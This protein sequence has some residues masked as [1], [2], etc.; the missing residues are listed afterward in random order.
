MDDTGDRPVDPARARISDRLAAVAAGFVLL[1]FVVASLLLARVNNSPGSSDSCGN[2]I[3][4]RSLTEG[5]GYVTGGLGELW[6]RQPLDAPDTVRPPGLPYLLAAVFAATGAALAVPVLVNAATVVLGALALR[7]AIRRRGGRRSADLAA[8]LML[9]SINYEMVSIWNNNLLAAFT[10]ALLFLASRAD[11]GASRGRAWLPVSLAVCSAA[12]L[13]MKQSFLLTAIP[14]SILVL[15]TDSTRTKTRRGLEVFAYLGLFLALTAVYWGPNVLLHGQPFYSPSFPSA[16]LAARYGFLPNGA[17]RTVRFDRPATYGEVLRALGPARMLLIDLKMLAKTIFYSICMN[18][19]VALAAAGSILFWRPSRRRD[20]AG[21]AALCA[22]TVFE[23][24]IYHHHE[25]R[26]LWP[27][28]PCFLLLA[29]FTVRDFDQWGTT[30][31]SPVLKARFRTAFALLGTCALLIGTFGALENWRK[32][33][34]QARQPTPGWAGAVRR[35][36]PASVVLTAD[37]G[38]V[39]WWTERRAVVSPLGDR[40]DLDAVLT[41]YKPDHYL[42]LGAEELPGRGVAFSSDDL[43]PLQQGEGWILYRIDLKKS[44]QSVKRDEPG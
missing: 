3:L 21:V 5:R 18:P 37:V 27:M 22:G 14:F 43:V 7:G 44:G 2:L 33:Y 42:A 25:F 32:A 9:L 30:Q 13:L 11:E 39:V 6:I 34:E 20:Y 40:A 8:I 36:P 17:W 26:Y 28:Y 10:A 23:V 15:A 19:A 38:P 41:F 16:R 1:V 35:L 31:V 24:G 4:A 12:G 29:W